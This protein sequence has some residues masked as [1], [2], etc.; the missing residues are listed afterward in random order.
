MVSVSQPEEL[1][2]WLPAIEETKAIAVQIETTGPDPHLDRMRLIRLAVDD[3]TLLTIDCTSFL[4]DGIELLRQV[5]SGSAVKVFHDAKP[6]LPFLMGLNIYPRPLFDTMLAA[7]LL[8][9]PDRP[10]LFDLESIV[11]EYAKQSDGNVPDADILLKLR[12][13]MIPELVK[14]GLVKVADIEFQC[15]HALAHVEYRGIHLDRDKW[16]SLHEK[17]LAERRI[18]KEALYHYTGCPVTQATLWGDEEVKGPNFDSNLFM[19]DLLRRNGINVSS[20]GKYELFPHRDHPLVMALAAYRKASKAISSFLQP[21]PAMIHPVTGRLHPQYGQMIAFSGRMS[22]GSPNIQQIPRD[23]PFRDCFSAPAGRRLIIADYSQIELR[24]TAQITGDERMT[25]A[26]QQGEDLHLLTASYLSNKPMS[27]ISKQERQEYKAVNL[28]LIYGMGAAGL[29]QTAQQSYG[30]D[31]A[32]EQAIIFRE[33][34]FNTYKGVVNWHKSIKTK[35][36]AEGRTLTGRRFAFRRE[37]GLP[38]RSNMP[39]QGT[40]ADIIKKALGSLARQLEGTDTWIIAV[41]HDEILLECP[42]DKAHEMAALLKTTMEAAANS[43]L[44][45]IPTTVEAK[46]SSSWAEK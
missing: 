40:A 30:V 4:P 34:F 22:C 2:P 38:E 28:G 27:L 35:S 37:A 8:H 23:Q 31:M 20:T 17:T 39:V 42:A 45:D 12:K 6:V 36:T 32:L 9:M 7:Q 1:L 5:L 25:A 43:I 44:P 21:I 13:T 41:V 18:A 10:Y 46:I 14:N 24:V 15:V 16:Q 29:Q 26:Y 3:G 33:R 19:L 11:K